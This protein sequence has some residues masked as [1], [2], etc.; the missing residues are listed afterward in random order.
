MRY[1]GG[2]HLL[3][4]APTRSGKGRDVLVPALLDYE[5]SCIVIDPKGQL[6]AVTRKRRERMGQRVIVLNPFNLLPDELG[7]TAHYNPMSSLDP[8]ALG[9]GADCDSI[10]DAVVV[11]EKGS[12][13]FFSESARQLIS[14]IMRYL[15][16]H[17]RDD[18]K[19][20][21]LVQT[22]VSGP[23]SVLGSFVSNALQVDPALV[24]GTLGR[25]EN[26]D[27]ESKSL[28]DIVSTANTQCGFIDNT[29]IGENLR[30][31]DF[32]FRDLKRLPTTVYLVLPAKYL[33][34][35]GKWF[36]LVVA[37]ALADLWSE[38]KGSVP[39]LAI[40]DEF[41][42]L[43]RLQAIQNAMGL[44]AGYGLQLWPVLQDLTQL[45]DLYGD[46]WET[47]LANA[48]VQQFFAPRENTTAEYI[49]NLCGQ[50]TVSTTSKSKSSSKTKPKGNGASA[51][52]SES[53]STSTSET[54]RQ[55]KLAQEIRQL[56]DSQFV[57]F[58]EGVQHVIEGFRQP[59]YK[60]PEFA[61]LYSADPY[62]KNEVQTSPKEYFAFGGTAP[63][64]P[65]F[66]VLDPNSVP[67]A[68][69]PDDWLI[70]WERGQ[71]Y[72]HANLV[73]KRTRLGV[74]IRNRKTFWVHEDLGTV[75]V[76]QLLTW[77]G[78]EPHLKEALAGVDPYFDV[79]GTPYLDIYNRA[80][81]PLSRLHEL[82]MNIKF[83]SRDF[84]GIRPTVAE[85]CQEALLVHNQAAGAW[86]HKTA[87]ERGVERVQRALDEMTE[88]DRRRPK[89]PKSFDERLD[90]T[91][92]FIA[93][94]DARDATPEYKVHLQSLAADVRGPG[95]GLSWSVEEK[96]ARMRILNAELEKIARWQ[97]ARA[98][99]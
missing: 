93:S 82:W 84:L 22:L 99:G 50:T 32:S 10:A 87:E 24:N 37:S 88:F 21:V 80:P 8:H 12:N 57:M 30:Y 56:S 64:I 66:T 44:A 92:A 47:F 28:R 86:P 41:A 16:T 63:P 98:T 19:N 95:P 74:C 51:S 18:Q 76:M 89:N 34:T 1:K 35:C 75:P 33:D 58:A 62:H 54:Q 79:I 83:G 5:G 72:L 4:V 9:F 42:Q 15:A 17:G 61:G 96:A 52:E 67:I 7:A 77:H 20:L 68:F 29:A 94:L 85:L 13:S 78:I 49:S 48:G 27:E 73:H 43:G 23:M 26:I 46:R 91:E 59:Y 6:A 31:S 38:E 65:G 81:W 25:F 53:E 69:S 97:Q 90:E 2:A 11:P 60:T 39:V 70:M 55:F 3:T 40:L 45:K 71:N 14:G 36:R